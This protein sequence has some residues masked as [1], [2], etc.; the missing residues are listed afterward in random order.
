MRDT[1]HDFR[2]F[3]S[4]Y[5]HLRNETLHHF[6]Y[7]RFARRLPRRLPSLLAV[8]TPYQLQLNTAY[9][10]HLAPIPCIPPFMACIPL[11]LLHK[12]IVALGVRRSSCS[13][14][15]FHASFGLVG[16]RLHFRFKLK[17]PARQSS[18][19][20]TPFSPSIVCIQFRRCLS[21]THLHFAFNNTFLLLRSRTNICLGYM[22][23]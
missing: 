6:V 5:Q 2:Y 14:R 7:P 22:L 9:V 4:F 19:S 11:T 15:N 17:A 8:R 16:L 12:K 23:S 3:I 1:R 18:A 10:S 21:C 13:A 20:R